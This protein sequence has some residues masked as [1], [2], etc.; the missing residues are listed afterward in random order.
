MTEVLFPGLGLSFNIDP[1]AFTVF[2]V[3]IYWYAICIC[4]GSA[5]AIL[6]AYKQCPKFGIDGDKLMDIVMVGYIAGIIGARIYY[7]AYKWSDYKDN[8]L[9]IF[10]FRNGGIAIY[11][12]IIGAI[13]IGTFYTKYKKQ[14]LYATYDIVG[15]GFLIG[16]CLG[17]WGNFFNQEAFGSNTTLPWGMYSAE[18]ERYLTSQKGLLSMY[19]IAVDPASPVHPCFLYESLWCLIGF[20]LLHF[21]IKHR[22]FD[23]EMFLMYISWYGAGRFVIEG[24]RTDSLMAGNFRISQLVALAC[25][26]GGVAAILYFRSKIKGENDPEF[27]KPFG[28]QE[29]WREQLA[30]DMAGLTLQEYMTRKEEL[31]KAEEADNEN[32]TD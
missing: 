12:G 28:K 9:E 4:T 31:P 27:M 1:V 13:L 26:I 11:G 15:L 24:L 6:Y 30:A 21:Y 18:T 19:N 10:N 7:V 16:Q 32:Q 25:V 5:L 2:G 14:P 17:R 20:V 23:G 22:K 8:L 29:N 3:D